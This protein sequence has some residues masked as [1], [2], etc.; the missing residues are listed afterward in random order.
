MAAGGGRDP[1]GAGVTL[2]A[3]PYTAAPPQGERGALLEVE[4]LSKYFP[5]TRGA[6]FRRVVGHVKAVDG[7]SFT[8]GRGETLGLVGESGCGKTTI[9][10][11][12]LK[13]EAGTGGAIRFA[14]RDIAELDRAET[15][16]FRRHVQAVFQDPFSSLNPRMRVGEI[17]G[18]PLLV[19]KAA[20]NS[21]AIA[22]RV[23]KLLDICGLSRRIARRFPHEL[24]GGQ[25]QRV[26]IARALA[27]R[28][29]FIVCDEAVSALDVS[30][31]AQIINLLES[32]REEFG[33][34]YL[35]ISHDLSVVRHLC[36]RAAVMYLGKIVEIADADDL[37][38]NPRHPYTNALL[39]AVPIP[40]PEIERERAHKVLGG[41][42]PSPIDPPPGCV[43]HT[44]C[45]R[46]VESCR[47]DV[48]E[49]REVAPGHW[50][51]CSQ[52][53]V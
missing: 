16:D 29:K 2:A 42:V 39:A 37:F 38:D 27:L 53:G 10:R 8:I 12:I 43:F 36:H 17:I 34:T 30:I 41:E 47:R 24:S 6:L 11:C 33:L 15:A 3:T 52:I 20:A 21:R 5:V 25:R 18:E 32:L 7:V 4:N 46:A 1:V 35:F 14:G 44:R 26:A 23:A 22:E 9:G 31:Q 51:A 50:A 28:P 45:P 40:D 48:P 13:L 19:H 49:L